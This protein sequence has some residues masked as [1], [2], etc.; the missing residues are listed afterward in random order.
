MKRLPVFALLG[1]LSCWLLVVAGAWIVFGGGPLDEG[2]QMFVGGLFGTFGVIL[3][4][5][6]ALAW[7]DGRLSRVR[8]RIP[9]VALVAFVVSVAVFFELTRESGSAENWGY[10]RQVLVDDGT[11][12]RPAGG[13]VCVGGGIVCPGHAAMTY[14]RRP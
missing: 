8:W 4:F 9:A 14:D 1:P 13:A 2:G 5:M 11:G 7:V 12:A 10:F 3:P 6:L